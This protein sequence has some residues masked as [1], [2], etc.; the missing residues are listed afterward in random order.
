MHNAVHR[1]IMDAV[2]WV[3]KKGRGDGWESEGEKVQVGYTLLTCGP[4][5]VVSNGVHI[6]H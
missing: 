6:L 2:C 4:P 3:G 5:L 1:L